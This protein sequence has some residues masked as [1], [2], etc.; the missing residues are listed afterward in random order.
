MFDSNEQRKVYFTPELTINEIDFDV[1]SAIKI[2]RTSFA[3]T[4]NEVLHLLLKIM[5]RQ[6]L[7]PDMKPMGDFDQPWS[8][9]SVTLPHGTEL[10]MEYNRGQRI[11]MIDEVQWLVEG[12]CFKSLLAAAGGVGLTKD[13]KYTLCWTAEILIRK[14]SRL[15]G[16][17]CHPA[18]EVMDGARHD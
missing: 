11:G 15:Y 2:E 6:T 10:R 9:S 7:N 1:N 16:L 4:A 5:E 8:G 17:D 18:I 14:T 12:K 13:G 3:E